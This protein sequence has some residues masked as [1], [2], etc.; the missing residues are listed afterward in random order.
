MGLEPMIVA[1]RK[2]QLQDTGEQ[3]K[4][5]KLTDF[6]KLMLDKGPQFLND[7]DNEDLVEPPIEKAWEEDWVEDRQQPP[8]EEQRNTVQ[9]P[10]QQML[11]GV[12]NGVEI[13]GIDVPFR[14]LFWLFFK[15]SLALFTALILVSFL[16]GLNL[17]LLEG[18]LTDF[19]SSILGIRS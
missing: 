11:A 12:G 18:P 5:E 15:G 7:W 8:T 10:R 9:P 4:A 3:E 2:D 16:M 6:Q 1:L 17:L 13:V 14:D 19:F